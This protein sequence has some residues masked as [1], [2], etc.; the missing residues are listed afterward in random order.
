VAFTWRYDSGLVVSGVPDAGTALTILSPNQQVSIGLACNG[1]FARVDTPLTDCTNPNGSM[2]KVTSKQ[3]T[4][5]QGGYGNFPSLENDDHN[6]DRV[7]PR[8]V[9]NL[10]LG[11][12]NLFHTEKRER[13]TASVDIANLTNRV[14][15][16]NFLSTFSGTH[17]LQPRTV[18][19][20][21][22]FVF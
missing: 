4:L 7:K 10:G 1:V 22:G 16:Y 17:F 3:I 2:G 6:P 18:V 13:I 8:N 21:V 12:D 20:R 14:A 19:A 15:L 5:P 9:F 11:T